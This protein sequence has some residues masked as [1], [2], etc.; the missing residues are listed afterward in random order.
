[1]SRQRPHQTALF[2]S[3]ESELSTLASDIDD[4]TGINPKKSEQET[5]ASKKSKLKDVDLTMDW[6]DINNLTGARYL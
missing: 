4:T 3:F 1:V 2:T 5:A 6:G